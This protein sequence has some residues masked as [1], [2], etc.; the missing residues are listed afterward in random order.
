MIQTVE[1]IIEPSGVVRWL[2]ELRV[3]RTRHAIQIILDEPP[4][5]AEAAYQTKLA[6]VDTTRLE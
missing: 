2:G 3:P 1:A 5:A 6:M 4:V